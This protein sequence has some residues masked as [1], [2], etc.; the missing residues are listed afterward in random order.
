MSFKINK[1]TLETSN[2]K[3]NAL[4]FK[5]N[6]PKSDYCCAFTHGYTS[7]KGSILP[8]AQKMMELSIP[9][10][11]FDLPGHFLGSFQEVQSFEVFKEQ[12][13][14][15]FNLAHEVLGEGRKLIS[16]GHSLGALFSLIHGQSNQPK[17]IFCAGLG[18]SDPAK[19][20]LFQTPFFK[21]T[22]NLRSELI[23]KSIAPEVVFPWIS[24]TKQNISCENKR[25][26][27]VAGKDD[28]I[29]DR[30]VGL[31]RLGDILKKK[32]HVEIITPPSLPHHQ[33]ERAGVYLK[34]TV[35]NLLNLP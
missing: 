22:M 4:A 20:H 13:P 33:P 21:D 10:I 24:E 12:T 23:S 3:V 34:Q 35:R 14:E 1:I 8:W 16:G 30:E 25:I 18:L 15:L 6:D 28:I 7:H 9:T 26:S 29:I 19:T 5:P 2:L 27:L 31:N 17:L 32:N 11:L